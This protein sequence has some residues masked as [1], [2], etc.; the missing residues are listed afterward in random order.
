MWRCELFTLRPFAPG[1]PIT[2][3]NYRNSI[4]RSSIWRAGLRVQKDQDRGIRDM[5]NESK[6]AASRPAL[7]EVA[8]REVTGRDVIERFQAQFRGA[9]LAC[10]K[11]LKGK[12]IDRVF[13]DHHDDFV[14]REN[15]DGETAYHFVQVKTKKAKKYQW[16]RAELFGLP[17][18]LPRVFKDTHWPGGIPPPTED[19]RKKI[20]ESFIG[21]LLLHT[22]YF[23]DACASITFQTNVHFDDDVE[24]IEVAL[25]SAQFDERTLRY[26]ADNYSAICGLVDPVLMPE[27]EHRIGKVRLCGENEFLHP[28][29]H[30]FETKT[31][32]AL[33]EFCEI[34][35]T[36][37]EGVELAVKLLDLVQRKS[38]AET[39][40]TMTPLELELSASV[41]VDDLLALLPI[42]PSAYRIFLADGDSKALKHASILQRKLGNSSASTAIVDAASKWKVAW[43]NWSRTYRH[44]YEK[45]LVFLQAKLN[46]IYGRWAGSEIA[47]GDIE[48]EIS[49]LLDGM[50]AT[51]MKA[52]LTQELLLGGIMSELVRSESR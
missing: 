26:L 16:T 49:D 13:C 25:L 43:D 17:K 5:V 24:E 21:K 23:R 33:Y 4:T 3:G 6:A 28:H 45:D 22:A 36:H 14:T 37:T 29:D 34:D 48:K 8:P 40:H 41:G 9:G 7:H 11:I 47:F 51:P 46:A 20:S 50:A 35:L 10:L 42:S 31:T 32:K 2:L 44:I 39:L 1:V 27:I 38:S 30:D 19:E 12:E 52:L 15:V 18:R